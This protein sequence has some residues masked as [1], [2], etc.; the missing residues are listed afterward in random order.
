[1]STGKPTY[2]PSDRNKLPDLVHFCVT[3]GI[4]Q[5]FAVRKSS[6]GAHALN[7]DIQPSLHNRHADWNGFRQLINKRLTSNV[8]IKTKKD[9]ETEVKS[10]FTPIKPNTIIYEG[11]P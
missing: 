10:F 2:F 4:P 3:K 9:I 6:L 5:D 8:Y 7:Q 11:C 1:M